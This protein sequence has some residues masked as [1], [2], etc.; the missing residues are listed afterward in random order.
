MKAKKLLCVLLAVMMLL[1]CFTACGDSG[2]TAGSTST[3]NQS[4]GNQTAGNQT[5]GTQTST[6]AGK[7]DD[8][9]CVIYASGVMSTLNF[10]LAPGY[11][12]RWIASNVYETL[13]TYDSDGNMEYLLAE[14]IETPDNRTVNVNIVK[15][16]KFHNGEPL[17]AEDVAFTL[18]EFTA[19][20]PLQNKYRKYIESV[21]VTGDYSVQIK[22]NQDNPV[23]LTYLKDFPI[24]CKSWV[25]AASDPDVKMEENGSGPYKVTNFDGTNIC[26][27]EAWAD[28]RKGEPAIKKAQIRYFADSSSAAVSFEAGEITVMDAPIAQGKILEASGNYNVQYVAPLHTAIIAFNCQKAP[29]DNKLVRQAFTYAA[30]KDTMI[31][32]AYDGMATRAEIQADVNSFGVDYSKATLFEYNPEKAKELLAEAGYPDGLDLTAMGIQFKTIAGGYHE[33]IAQIYQQ[34]LKDIGVNVEIIATETP[35]EDCVAG[36]YHIMNEGQGYAYEFANNMVQYSSS[37]INGSNFGQ[38]GD[39]YADE[40]WEKVFAEPDRNARLELYKDLV[41][42]IIDACP[43]LPI[44]HRQAMYLYSKD[45][46]ASFYNDSGHPYRIY[47]WSW[48]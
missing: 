15:D 44:F 26:D 20:F 43:T 18:D 32:I 4:A 24:F 21:T 2:N 42:Y 17:T 10:Y 33:K 19:R 36:D 28:Y 41:A 6:D 12:D 11:P 5:T 37:G 25:E 8:R 23:F 16:A 7:N 34:N 38:W 13:V 14:S 31:Q 35:D 1:G 47:D 22:L 29:F 39:S 45:L 27:L 9:T 30:D 40:M 3:E 48:N 46:N